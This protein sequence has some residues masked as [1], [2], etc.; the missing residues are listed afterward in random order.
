MR[1]FH[2]LCESPLHDRSRR[3]PVPITNQRRRLVLRRKWRKKNDQD[4]PD[5][6]TR[7]CGLPAPAIT[8]AIPTTR[9]PTHTYCS[10]QALP[11]TR[12]VHDIDDELLPRVQP[13]VALGEVNRPNDIGRGVKAW[14]GETRQSSGSKTD[15]TLRWR[16]TEL[17]T[18]GSARK[19]A[20]QELRRHE[21]R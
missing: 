14:C 15:K 16:R 19:G 17:W 11:P 5:H 21:S 4:L 3:R 13:A 12:L 20:I 8:E 10:P 9:C 2:V 6:P 1:G 18:P 7:L